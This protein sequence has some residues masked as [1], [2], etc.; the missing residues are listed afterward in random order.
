MRMSARS[1][2][3]RIARRLALALLACVLSLALGEL[4]LRTFLPQLNPLTRGGFLDADPVLGWVLHPGWRASEPYE[5]AINSLGMR[6][7]ELPPRD[8]ETFRVLVVGDSFTFGA[9]PLA[10]TYVKQLEV[11]L[12]ERDHDQAVQVLNGGVP[13]YSPTQELDALRR[14]LAPVAP[15]AILLGLFVG[16]DFD[17]LE[18]DRAAK[19]C[20]MDGVLVDSKTVDRT[21]TAGR[22]PTWRGRLRI[23][24]ART[25]LFQLWRRVWPTR[26]SEE[27]EQNE[28]KRYAWLELNRLRIYFS[29]PANDAWWQERLR[30]MRAALIAF[31]KLS[32]AEPIPLG[33]A[34][35]PDVA[36]VEEH[37]MERVASLRPGIGRVPLDF[38]RPQRALGEMLRELELPAID[39][40][41]AFRER[42]RSGPLYGERDTHWNRDGNTLAASQM[43]PLLE[44]LRAERRA[45]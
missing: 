20:V 2:G 6:D 5:I 23:L 14:W 24:I 12:R 18:P 35:F 43:V 31:K 10:E 17:E 19:A 16:N 26:P 3:G 9:V 1:L 45:R 37:V 8:P 13:S 44:Q 40:L 21:K 36:Q 38:E 34:I 15:D 28:D 33:V 30:R 42:A 4:V 25:H 41:P 27:D 29:D 11:M 32:A 39:L 22:A 7:G